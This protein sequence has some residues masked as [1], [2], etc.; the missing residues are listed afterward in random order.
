MGI[1]VTLAML[2]GL[3]VLVLSPSSIFRKRSSD[4][5]KMTIFSG[6]FLLLAG[7]W[8]TFWHGLQNLNVFWGLAAFGTGLV[9]IASALV[10]LMSLRHPTEFVKRRWFHYFL[11]TALLMSFSLYVITLVQIYS[12]M[13]ILG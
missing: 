4:Y 6:S 12:G 10:I 11:I 5:S 13:E 8:N 7:L 2:A 3:W 1:V 9:M